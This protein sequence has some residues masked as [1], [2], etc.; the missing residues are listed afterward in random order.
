MNTPLLLLIYN[1]PKE[2]QILI[3]R[4]KKFKPKYL[5]IFSDGPKKNKKD[6]DLNLECKKII[7]K[8]NWE[9]KIKKYYL[10]KI[11]DVSTQ[12]QLV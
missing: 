12:S 6:H 9:V 11:M 1:R 10:K 7:D 2:T 3:T 8:I 4:L 5:Y